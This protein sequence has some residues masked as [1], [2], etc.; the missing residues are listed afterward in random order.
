[1]LYEL[2]TLVR[3]AGPRAGAALLD[4][5]FGGVFS[6]EVG[7]MGE[8][9]VI[10]PNDLDATARAARGEGRARLEPSVAP[11]TME[12]LRPAPFMKDLEAQEIGKVYE[13]SWFD[14]PTG[15]VGPALDAIGAALPAREQL[16]PIT[17][18]W[19]VEVGPAL[20][21]VYILTPYRDWGHRHEVQAKQGAWPPA[22]EPAAIAA[23][24]KLLLPTQASGLK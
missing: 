7:T 15:G 4:G 5:G 1:M 13:L 9:V 3:G 18:V 21:R 10:R 24:S 16:H 23:G 6:T 2:R 17:G 20:D 8:T 22:F 12:L 11:Q 19:S 14:F